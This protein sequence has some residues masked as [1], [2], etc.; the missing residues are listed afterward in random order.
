MTLLGALL[1]L[2]EEV[3]GTLTF[4][5]SCR[6]A[7]CGSCLMQVNGIQKLA[8]TLSLRDEMERHG[9]IV[10]APMANM[11]VIKDMVV[12]MAPFWAKLRAVTPYVLEGMEATP[13]SALQ[14]LPETMHNAD[15]CILCGACLSACTSHEVSSGFLGPAAL[16]KAYRIQADPRDATHPARLLALQGPGG[17]WDCVRCNFCVQVCPKDVQPMEQI[18]RLRRMSL[19]A[20]LTQSVAARHITQFVKIVA[21]EGRLNEALLPLQ[22]TWRSPRLLLRMIPLGLRMLL[23]GK[24]PFPFKSA[25]RTIQALFRRRAAAYA[26][27]PEEKQ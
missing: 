21:H 8:C 12:Q 9:K 24:V 25:H 16:A 11:P 10:V 18:I 20:G 14:T 26:I 27:P 13:A 2:K 1:Q 22:M 7:I 6:A 23:H 17:I 19:A 3:D 15:G 5:A 4:R